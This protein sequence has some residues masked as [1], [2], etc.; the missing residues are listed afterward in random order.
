MRDGHNGYVPSVGILAAR[1]AVAAELSR[2]RHAGVARSR[3]D[4]VGHVG[5]HRAGADGARRGRATRCWCRRRPI[6]STPRCWRRLAREPVF[7][8]TDPAQRLAA[9]PRSRRAA[10]SLRRRARSSSSIRTIRPARSIPTDVG[11]A[12]IEIADTHD[13][14]ILADE[15]YGDLA[16]DGPVPPMASL[17]PDAP[18]ISFSSLSKAYLAPGWR[19]GWLAVGRT[20]RLDDVLARSRSWRTA[21]CAAPARCSTRS[22]PR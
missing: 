10:W 4:H 22:P 15:V 5:R 21:G 7:Y 14:L 9:R 1:E 13:I 17:D 12:L 8:R 2:P 6:R 16:Y 19:A 3:A 11:A 20:E 18:I